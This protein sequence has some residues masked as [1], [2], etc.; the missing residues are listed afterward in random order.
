M[1]NKESILGEPIFNLKFIL[2][3]IGFA[4]VMFASVITFTRPAFN[5]FFDFSKT[6]Q[7]G[8][9]IGGITAPVI[10]LIGAVL[11]F[12]SF[13]AQINA[14]KI[15]FRLLET[16][17]KNQKFDRNFQI[18]LELFKE[19]KEDFQNLEYKNNSGKP[20]L[21]I[22]T[23]EIKRFRNKAAVESHGRKPIYN[24]W[25]FIIHEYNLILNHIDKAEIRT[26]EKEQLFSM[27]NKYYDTQLS[28]PTR[29]LRKQFE[30][31][32]MAPN[33]LNLIKEIVENHRKISKGE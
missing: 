17:I 7:I 19:L 4:L 31:F 14:N 15:Q 1:D 2:L 8:D 22:F 27:I 10:N 28:F 16:E 23:N 9:T 11:I 21:N 33:T 3:I 30:K 20:A 26:G 32:K 13:K 25:Y 6:G 29:I 12:I 5:N 24:N 18:T